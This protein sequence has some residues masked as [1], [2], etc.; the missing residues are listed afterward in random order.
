MSA[1]L[2]DDM[3]DDTIPPEHT[4]AAVKEA[5]QLEFLQLQRLGTDLLRKELQSGFDKFGKD[6]LAGM[7]GVISEE[8]RASFTIGGPAPPEIGLPLPK[9]P[10]TEPIDMNKGSD[11]EEDTK[12]SED[13]TEDMQR[14]EYVRKVS[15]CST[16]S[17]AMHEPTNGNQE[18]RVDESESRSQ[19]SKRKKKSGSRGSVHSVMSSCEL[20]LRAAQSDI[21]LEAPTTLQEKVQL[22]VK[23]SKFDYGI[24]IIL[25]LNSILIGIQVELEAKEVDDLY[26]TFYLINAFFCLIFTLELLLRIFA[27]R[28]KFFTEEWKWNIF[29]SVLV[30][31]LIGDLIAS[32][33]TNQNSSVAFVKLLRI[34]RIVRIVRM[35]RLI[36]SLKQM[37]Y[38]IVASMGCFV[39][40]AFLIFMVMYCFA[41]FFTVQGSD[42]M[43]T[44]KA[45]GVHD[46]ILEARW[47]SIGAS[48]TS[49]FMAITGG[50]N[51]LRIIA[52]L[53]RQSWLNSVVFYVYIVFTTLVM[54]NL[55]T[56]VF[57]DGAT[58][59]VGQDREREVIKTAARVFARMDTD[60]SGFVNL[61]EFFHVEAKDS[62]DEYCRCLDISSDEARNLFLLLDRDKS[63]TLSVAEFVEGCLKLHGPARSM[64]LAQCILST[65]AVQS[66]CEKSVKSIDSIEVQ[67]TSLGRA[68]EAN[69]KR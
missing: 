64:D 26:L 19:I 45:A 28:F 7:K 35:V 11:D 14:P 24:G 59:I 29:D 58:R 17:F 63:G 56:G 68:V 41:I 61:D 20:M 37:V 69:S 10:M 8:R 9:P 39:W 25:A 3:A 18:V 51:W 6:L 40:A 2:V 31:C 42:L 66:L 67:L 46:E 43:M 38:L 32:A 27:L 52:P 23:S 47:S 53:A 1:G 16:M 55:V 13:E 5:L 30:S 60:L 48:I 57:V 33:F 34:V 22:F 65:Q 62:L 36:P 54:L 50:E 44:Y 15:I 12:E 49:L 21:L 4:V